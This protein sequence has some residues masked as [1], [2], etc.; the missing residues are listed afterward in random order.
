[1]LL[2]AV[3]FSAL[4]KRK[5]LKKKKVGMYTYQKDGGF[6]ELHYFTVSKRPFFNGKETCDLIC[7]S[8]IPGVEW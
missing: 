1:M 7:I 6:I 2:L 5:K 3:Y 4:T 8:N